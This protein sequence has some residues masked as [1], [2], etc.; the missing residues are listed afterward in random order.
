MAIDSPEK[1][2]S[3]SGLPHVVM[4]PGVTPNA[5]KDQEW[6]QE[7]G[8]GYSGV[9]AAAPP[10]PPVLGAAPSGF[11]VIGKENRSVTVSRENKSVV[12]TR[13]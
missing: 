7:S 13:G 8:W 9:L 12:V 5:A 1:R 11:I 10:I 6:R 4:I 3:I 2:K